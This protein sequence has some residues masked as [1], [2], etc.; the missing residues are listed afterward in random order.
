[1][2]LVFVLCLAD[3]FSN[4]ISVIFYHVC[5]SGS[6]PGDIHLLHIYVVFCAFRRLYNVYLQVL[7][8]ALVV[9]FSNSI[10]VI[11]AFVV[12]LASACGNFISCFLIL[13]DLE[14]ILYPEFIVVASGCRVF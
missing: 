5:A 6:T 12:T 8:L 9:A 4:S 11:F 7:L 14:A 13:V 2:F 3:A 1:M 10:S